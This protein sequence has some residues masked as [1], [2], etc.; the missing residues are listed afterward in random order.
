MN[1][2][3]AD[4]KSQDASPEPQEILAKNA[5]AS[6]AMGD[7]AAAGAG[8]SL[9]AGSGPRTITEAALGCLLGFGHWQCPADTA[10]YWSWCGERYE[11][12]WVGD[13]PEGPLEEVNYLGINAAGADVYEARYRH[14]DTTAIIEPHGPDG[15][16]HVHFIKG[17]PDGIIPSSLVDVASSAA[18]KITLYRGVY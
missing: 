10:T 15:K 3:I 1:K 13:C 7:A 18:R 11:Q 4:Q 5:V 14:T 16:A 2:I 6:P 8:T 17:N 9:A 12:R